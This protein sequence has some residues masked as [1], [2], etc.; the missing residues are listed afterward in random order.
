MVTR[1]GAFYD[2]T[3]DRVGDGATFIGIGAF[4][5][6][7]PDVAYRVP[8]TILCMIA[9]LGSLLVSYARARAEG[10]GLDCKVGIAQR[11]ERVLGLGVASL[12]AGAG[13]RAL[14][15][16]A[17]VTLLALASIITVVQRFVYVYRHAGRVDEALRAEEMMQAEEVRLAGGMKRPAEVTRA[18]LDPFAKGRS[19]G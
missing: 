8:A 6:T 18:A 7:A 2:S 15:L 4:L 19:S 5:L 11:A 1:F 3:L 16:E 10:L 14:L 13:Q 9:I 17:M 12:L